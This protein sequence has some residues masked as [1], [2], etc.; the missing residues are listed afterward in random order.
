MAL[1]LWDDLILVIPLVATDQGEEVIL[2][3]HPYFVHI[4]PFVPEYPTI[5]LFPNTPQNHTRKFLPEG[6]NDPIFEG[7]GVPIL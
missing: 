3:N 1:L 5:P 7:L 2:K 4:L 6:A